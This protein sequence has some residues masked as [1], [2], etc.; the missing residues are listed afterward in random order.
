MD[1]DSQTR[2]AVAV[3]SLLGTCVLSVFA[4]ESSRTYDSG[5]L[6]QAAF[7]LGG[8]HPPGQV[9]YSVLG[10]A[11]S[12][13]PVGSFSLR[14]A[15]LSS[16]SVGIAAYLAGVL[17]L[18]VLPLEQTNQTARTVMPPVCT[19]SV[20]CLEPVLRQGLRIEVYAIALAL[21]LFATASAKRGELL[22]AAIATGLLAALHP[23]HAVATLA[24]VWVVSM[25]RATTRLRVAVL[26]S[27]TIVMV[28]A[29]L[30]VVLPLRAR[31]DAPMWG[32]PSTLHGLWSYLSGSAYRQNLQTVDTSLATTILDVLR[33]A[34]M[35]SPLALLGLVVPL[36]P[37]M[38]ARWGAVISMPLVASIGAWFQPLREENPDN[39]AYAQLTVV[40]L[41]VVAAASTAQLISKLPRQY[42]RGLLGVAAIAL[43]LSS[44]A[45]ALAARLSSAETPE[46]DA[47]DLELAE[48]PPSRALV[49]A[50]TDYVA[51]QWMYAQ[52]VE[53]QR[54]D[55]TLFVAGFAT[56]S[57]QWKEAARR[58]LI[59]STP[60][61]DP[62]LRNARDAYLLG[63][64]KRAVPLVEVASEAMAPMNKLGLPVRARGPYLV[65]QNHR[66]TNAARIKGSFTLMTAGL[67]AHLARALWRSVVDEA[68]AQQVARWHFYQQALRAAAA[69]NARKS[70]RNALWAAAPL[71]PDIRA[72]VWQLPLAS[73]Q[74]IDET[75]LHRAGYL[76]SR[77][78]AR[79]LLAAVLEA[80]VGPP[81]VP[82]RLLARVQDLAP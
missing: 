30:V 58:G 4:A 62:T 78:D 23:P 27:I 15:I 25:S 77:A 8:S 34:W 81:G 79:T 17:S 54:P 53:G 29:M 40:L 56:S 68:A 3:V 12:L 57:W 46:L 48:A 64:I 14:L 13:L 5:E 24:V 66:G 39:I 42:S 45:M 19:A 49:V 72:A 31:A 65:T 21:A 82:R 9:L 74:P 26:G 75:K 71:P 6:A 32:D 22:R 50:Q 59:S 43:P 61:R 80:N 36:R 52:A 10:H 41:L 60:V 11:C 47:F 37:P 63:A 35:C 73:G 38:P 70:I 55:V 28:F 16:V 44:G 51:A 33:Y 7:L 2:W 20:F 69:G 67:D 76:A 18:Q 1:T